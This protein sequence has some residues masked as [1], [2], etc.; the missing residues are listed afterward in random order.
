MKY[1]LMKTEPEAFSIDDLQKRGT[2]SWDGVRSYQARNNMMAMKLGDR[3]FFYHSSTD[4]IGIAGVCE[5]VREAYPDH[6]AF[7]PESKYFDPASSQD[8][9]RWYMVDVGFVEKFS[10]IVTLSEIRE[11]PGLENMF[12][13]RRGAR[14]SVQPVTPEEWEIILGVAHR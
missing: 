8:K 9:P 4:V 7:D 5:I 13:T 11:T 12:V 2:E 14:L 6:T 10:R 3:A 1:W